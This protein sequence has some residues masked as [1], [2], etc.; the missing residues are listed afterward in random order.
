MKTARLENMVKGWFVGDFEP[1]LLASKEAEVAIKH[2][3]KGDKEAEHVHKI[4]TEVTAIVTGSVKMCGKVFSDGDIILL[5]PGE[6][7]AFEA[8][9]DTTTVVVKTPSAKN[10]KFL[11]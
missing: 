10:D 7:C 2:Y 3:K 11:L 1:T 6:P 5:E 8:L 4:G 9:T